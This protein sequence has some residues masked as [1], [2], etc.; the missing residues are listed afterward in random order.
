MASAAC[1][2]RPGRLSQAKRFREGI[3][4]LER[5]VARSGDASQDGLLAV[6]RGLRERAEG[7]EATTARQIAALSRL[8]TVAQS[9]RGLR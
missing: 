9:R 3:E 1:P 8:P 6:V 2:P 4:K 7:L 5:Q